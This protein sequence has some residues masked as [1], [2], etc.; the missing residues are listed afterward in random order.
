MK[1]TVYTI[2]DCPFSKQEKDYLSANKLAFEEKNLE[3]NK[4]FLTEMLAVSNNFA[5]TPV[6]KV[7]KDDGQIAVLKGFTKE[8]F[9]K[10]F[11]FETAPKPVEE[12]NAKMDIPPASTPTPPSIST[13]PPFEPPKTETPEPV[14]AEPVSA[15]ATTGEEKPAEQTNVAP[16]PLDAILNDLKTKSGE[17]TT[18]PAEPVVPKEETL[19]PTPPAETLPPTTTPPSIPTTPPPVTET[20]PPT[21]PDF[22]AK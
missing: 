18:K 3:S 4:E 9:D 6:T 15:E 22:Q 21:I 13:S 12:T 7:E 19:P 14:K 17:E 11:S 10:T 1:I 2:N 20:T 5:G 8:E 16:D